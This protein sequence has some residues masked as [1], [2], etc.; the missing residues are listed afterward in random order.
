MRFE[1]SMVVLSLAFILLAGCAKPGPETDVQLDNAIETMLEALRARDDGAV[2]SLAVNPQD[3]GENGRLD[4]DVARFLYDGD[5]LRG[6]SPDA[7]SVVEIMALGPLRVHIVREQGGRATVLF[8]PERFEEKAEVVSFYAQ[9]WMRDYFACE[10]HL[11]DGRWVLLY[12]I[13]FALTD[14][15]YPEP[16]GMWHAPGNA[17]RELA[18]LDPELRRRP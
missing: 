18:R 1:L 11:I 7:R 2:L 12:N 4:D 16:Y 15:P 10:F 5:Y 9:R 6:F 13:C 8:I 17:P 14:G 3:I